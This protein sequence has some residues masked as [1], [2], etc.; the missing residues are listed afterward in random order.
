MSKIRASFG[1]SLDFT[2]YLLVF[3]K[4]AARNESHIGEHNQ[5][6]DFYS[7]RVCVCMCVCV[8]LEACGHQGAW[9]SNLT[10]IRKYILG[11]I[12]SVAA[13]GFKLE[14]EERETWEDMSWRAGRTDERRRHAG[15]ES[16]KLRRWARVVELS[17]HSTLLSLS[18]AP[19][20]PTRSGL[21]AFESRGS[22]GFPG[23]DVHRFLSSDRPF[24][25][26]PTWKT[27]TRLCFSLS[28]S[29]SLYLSLILFCLFHTMYFHLIPS[30]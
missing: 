13:R 27:E 30:L 16:E 5:R 4:L 2:N 19:S 12:P 9:T 24:E 1:E 25:Q 23:K 14:G 26:Q 11:L 10:R 22:R 17:I 18:L 28:L 20:P 15:R 6:N 29:L 7:R 8:A 3:S 21:C